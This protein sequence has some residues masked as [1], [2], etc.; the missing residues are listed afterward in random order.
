MTPC[1][2]ARPRAGD[3]ARVPARARRSG[4]ARAPGRDRRRR[5][6]LRGRRAARAARRPRAR[7]R[8]LPPVG[9]ARRLAG[10]RLH[11]RAGLVAAAALRARVR[12]AR[13]AGP[14][15]AARFELL[16]TLGA[17]GLYELEPDPL[18]LG[19]RT[20][21]R[22]RPPSGRCCRATRCCSSAAR[23]TSRPPC[24][25]PLAAL[26]RGLALWD[27]PGARV[28]V[29][30][31]SSPAAM[32]SALALQVTAAAT[33]AGAARRGGCSV[34][35]CLVLAALAHSARR[36]TYDPWAWIAGAAR[37]PSGIST[38]APARRGSRCRCC[39]RR[40][41]RSTGDDAAPELWLVVAQ[42]GGLLAFA[43]T[44][45]LARGSRAGRRG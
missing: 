23:A 14:G 4:R 2:R 19:S 21:R 15:R 41:S 38:R 11:R 6:A 34:L 36:P 35:G 18:Q 28:R 43:F 5:A 37:S 8:R 27:D 7:D 31:R 3:L 25:V 32:R 24:D 45:R 22:P 44:Y 29:A 20:T 39:S 9:G 33:G 16:A 42:A 10:R 12:A 1:D 30:A 40:R 17:A 13:A 26:D